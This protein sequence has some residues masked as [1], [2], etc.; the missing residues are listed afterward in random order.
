M[1][2]KY[3]I[4]ASGLNSSWSGKCS[5]SINDSEG[6]T[7]NWATGPRSP[8]GSQKP[9]NHCVL[10][11]VVFRVTFLKIFLKAQPIFLLFYTLSQQWPLR[12]FTLIITSLCLC[13]KCQWRNLPSS[14]CIEIDKRNSSMQSSITVFNLLSL[15]LV[16][17]PGWRLL[18]QSLLLADYFS[19]HSPPSHD[20]R[21][22]ISKIPVTTRN[23]NNNLWAS[24]LHAGIARY[25]GHLR[26]EHKQGFSL[27]K[28]RAHLPL[29]KTSAL[30]TLF[31]DGT[32]LGFSPSKMA[33]IYRNTNK[34][35]IFYYCCFTSSFNWWN[36]RV[37]FI[38]KQCKENTM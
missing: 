16:W 23:N 4:R 36:T 10:R 12:G 31:Q 11:I 18:A 17:F 19:Q 9:Q 14:W 25:S 3:R 26:Y 35:I 34:H 30:P 24:N 22:T 5:A 15:I 27:C 7:I 6:W 20:L 1:F 29:C 21:V 37:A 8:R 32:I 2:W 33:A 28:T 13:F 38:L